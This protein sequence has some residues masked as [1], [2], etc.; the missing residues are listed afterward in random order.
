MQVL[1]K[2]SSLEAS[3][4]FIMSFIVNPKKLATL[5]T[6]LTSNLELERR[7][8]VALKKFNMAA[9]EFASSTG[10]TSNETVKWIIL[11]LL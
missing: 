9:T 1:Q 2:N 4:V 11:S 7:Q 5:V 6:E 3:I 10:S 8:M